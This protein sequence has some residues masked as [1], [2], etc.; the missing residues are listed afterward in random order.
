MTTVIETVDPASSTSPPTLRILFFISMLSGFIYGY[1]AGVYSGVML[2]IRDAFDLSDDDIADLIA[3]FDFA[4]VT[5]VFL[6]PLADHLGRKRLMTICASALV[7]GPLLVL[8]HPSVFFLVIDRFIG[9]CAAGILFMTAIVYVAEIATEKRRAL[10]L[11]AVP[12]G[13]SA[14]YVGELLLSLAFVEGSGWRIAIAGSALPAL[15]QIAGLTRLH[16]SPH[17]LHRTGHR[18]NAHKAWTW[19]GLPAPSEGT[20]DPPNPPWY[21]APKLL[22][23]TAESRRGLL[24]GSI[25][26]LAATT[27]GSGIIAYGP[28][29]FDFFGQHDTSV[30]LQILA[31]YTTL[32]FLMAMAALKLIDEG[33]TDKILVG[34]LLAMAAAQFLLA[35]S[36]GWTAILLFGVVQ[37]AFSF[38]IRTTAFQIL[39]GFLSDA[40]RTSG[41]AFFN[42]VFMSL[43]GINAEI[44]PRVL[45]DSS[46]LLFSL[47]SA[48]A[49]VLAGSCWLILKT[50]SKR[51]S[52]GL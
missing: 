33:H 28:L 50:K 25:I 19:Y 42:L 13:V 34:S 10:L 30:T 5:G 12:V 24:L 48:I 1:N 31:V 41:V 4:E 22:F 39:P 51:E 46:V 44:V 7:A 14:G 29:L 16:E 8:I 43:S 2:Q 45:Q 37:L 35:I 32:G 26:V 21:H 18:Q 47:Y 17:F 15:V 3:L 49:F 27:C 52:P 20:E 36:G 11:S 40:T 23:A 38:G 9:G 6:V